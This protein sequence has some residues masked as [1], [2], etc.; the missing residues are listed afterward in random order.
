MADQFQVMCNTEREDAFVVHVPNNPI[1]F[2]RMGM[3]QYVFKLSIKKST[4]ASAQYSRQ[5][6][7]DVL[8]ATSILK[9]PS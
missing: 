2:E 1:G 7:D 9:E 8:Q 5:K 4:E 3:N 6:Q